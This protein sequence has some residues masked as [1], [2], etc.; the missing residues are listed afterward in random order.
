MAAVGNGATIAFGTGSFPADLTSITASGCSREAIETTT[1]A[2]TGAKTYIPGFLVEN[3][4]LSVEGYW[5][6]TEPPS[7][8]EPTSITVTVPTSTSTTK[9]LTGS[10]FVTQWSWGA[11]LEELVSFSATVKWSGAVTIS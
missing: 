8:A 1:L 4:E 5:E 9:T 10:G 3:G 2:T 11:P 6:G 7:A